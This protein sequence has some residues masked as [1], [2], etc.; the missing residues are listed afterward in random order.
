MHPLSAAANCTRSFSRLQWSRIHV[1]PLCGNGSSPRLDQDSGRIALMKTRTIVRPGGLGDSLLLAPSLAVLKNQGHDR[2]VL[3][4]YPERLEPL[5]SAGLAREVYSLDTWLT[6]PERVLGPS[7]HPEDCGVTVDSFFPQT[8]VGLP[9]SIPVAYHPPFPPEVEPTHVAEHIAKC[10]AVELKATR[11]SPLKCLLPGLDD[12]ESGRIW[13]HPGAGSPEKRWLW[14]RFLGLEKE[15]RRSSERRVSF[16]LGEAEGDIAEV[17]RRKWINVHTCTSVSDLL[18][19]FRKNDL[20]IGNDSGPSH[21]AGLL[22]LR[23]LAIF[24]PT[25]PVQW[26]P[27]GEDVRVVK[28]GDCDEWPTLDRVLKSLGDWIE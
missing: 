13:I 5:R 12:P 14:Q 15:L 3:V 20:Y 7:G 6:V 8:P 19:L 17:F 23:T 10:L 25:D 2:V 26:S 22:G 4:G 18:S 16:L 27:W 9:S 28:P 24:G 11:D 21:L 1:S